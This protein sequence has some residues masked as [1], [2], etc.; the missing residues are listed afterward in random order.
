MKPASNLCATCRENNSNLSNLANLSTE[1]QVKLIETARSHLESAR[2][3]R[4][5][6]N[7]CREK[8]KNEIGSLL[9][10]SFTIRLILGRIVNV[11]FG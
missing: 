8:A 11:G 3:Q 7:S 2:E 5:Y 4:E 10:I 9:I 1:K 6:Y